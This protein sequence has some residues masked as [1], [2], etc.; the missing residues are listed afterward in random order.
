MKSIFRSL[1]LTL[2]VCGFLQCTLAD[3]L[4]EYNRKSFVACFFEEFMK[5]YNSNDAEKVVKMSATTSRS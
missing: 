2:L 5:A 3:K 1:L 4:A